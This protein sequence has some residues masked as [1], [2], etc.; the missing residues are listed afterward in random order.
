[1]DTPTLHLFMDKQGDNMVEVIQGYVPIRGVIL[2]DDRGYLNASA[3]LGNLRQIKFYNDNNLNYLDSIRQLE[4]HNRDYERQRRR[5]N[6]HEITEDEEEEITESDEDEEEADETEEDGVIP[7][8]SESEEADGKPLKNKNK[9]KKN[10]KGD[11][12]KAFEKEES[13]RQKKIPVNQTETEED[14]SVMEHKLILEEGDQDLRQDP[15]TGNFFQQLPNGTQVSVKQISVVGKDGKPTHVYVNPT[16]EDSVKGKAVMSKSELKDL[17]KQE[18]GIMKSLALIEPQV[19]KLGKKDIH[20]DRESKSPNKETSLNKKKDLK[21]LRTDMDLDSEEVIELKNKK[22]SEKSKLS[23][24]SSSKLLNLPYI[25]KDETSEE[26][27]RVSP[28]SRHRGRPGPKVEIQIDDDSSLNTKTNKQ[29]SQSSPKKKISKKSSMGREE[30]GDSDGTSLIKKNSSRLNDGQSEGRAH[31]DNQVAKKG[32]VVGNE[33][34]RLEKSRTSRGLKTEG[35]DGEEEGESELDQSEVKSQYISIDQHSPNN[36]K[37][38]SKPTSTVSKLE[39]SR[40]LKIAARINSEA[41]RRDAYTPKPNEETSLGGKGNLRLNKK[42]FD[43]KDTNPSFNSLDPRPASP[44]KMDKSS[45]PQIDEENTEN[46]PERVLSPLSKTAREVVPQIET[47]LN[48]E[49]CSDDVI[50]TYTMI[51]EYLRRHIFRNE[52]LSEKMDVLYLG[53]YQHELSRKIQFVDVEQIMK[54]FNVY[55]TK[56][57]LE[58]LFDM[59]DLKGSGTID[60]QCFHDSMIAY[61]QLYEIINLEFYEAFQELHLKIKKHSSLEDFKDYLCDSQELTNFHIPM[62]ALKE[63]LVSFL[64]ITK[65]SVFTKVMQNGD[66]LY[67]D[68]AYI[69]NILNYLLFLEHYQ[70]KEISFEYIDSLHNYGKFVGIIE[71]KAVV[72]LAQTYKLDLA[73]RAGIYN[74]FQ[75]KFDSCCD[76]YEESITFSQFVSLMGEVKL[77]LTVWEYMIIFKEALNYQKDHVE[78][79]LNRLQR[80]PLKQ[81][82]SYFTGVIQGKRVEEGLQG[83]SSMDIQKGISNFTD[84]KKKLKNSQLNSEKFT[85]NYEICIE[86]ISDLNLLGCDFCDLSLM[87]QFPGEENPIESQAF[88]YMPDEHRTNDLLTLEFEVTVSS[89]HSYSLL[90]KKN[91][92]D[93]FGKTNGLKIILT[94]LS[95]RKKEGIGMAVIPIDDLINLSKLDVTY[96]I[97]PIN[98]EQV[99]APIIPEEKRVYGSVAPDS[100]LIRDERSHEPQR[101]PEQ[102]A[103]PR[104]Q[105]HTA[106]LG[107]RTKRPEARSHQLL[108]RVALQA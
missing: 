25:E 58:S 108:H 20:T 57:E 2:N 24:K 3:S 21:F 92:M 36:L 100:A 12:K 7:E 73:E 93:L 86:K 71:Y 67:F 31:S 107:C 4:D 80:L 23:K 41:S 66:F 33:K 91:L 99:T 88:T 19:N 84:N 72:S 60:M 89:K 6:K 13:K 18:M 62:D 15:K 44:F 83:V 75:S 34:A 39:N 104:R 49:F 87:Y 10:K 74:I 42:F 55:I 47:I 53:T 59:L 30:E 46:P 35:F 5:L 97:Y 54:S 65:E 106:R 96:Y 81:A 38:D 11:P 16:L 37:N 1:M 105:L 70:A 9:N 103:R 102:Q 29:N 51:L 45:I 48:D 22:G 68:Q 26:E 17:K 98:E 101:H 40:N 32:S 61:L 14:E 56:L 63:Y 64:G 82:S 78:L 43:F 94:K 28:S 69:F 90:K 76:N 27:S 95:R 79:N 85:Y 77:K 8:V 52:N 50:L